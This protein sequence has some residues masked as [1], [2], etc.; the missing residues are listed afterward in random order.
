MEPIRQGDCDFRQ[1]MSF[2]RTKGEWPIEIEQQNELA[3]ACMNRQSSILNTI[4]GPHDDMIPE[5]CSVPNGAGRLPVAKLISV[6]SVQSTTT[7]KKTLT[8]RK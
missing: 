2:C 1:N 3:F 4:T 6:D 7:T 5:T 8:S